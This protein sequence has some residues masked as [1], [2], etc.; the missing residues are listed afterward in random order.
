MKWLSRPME[1]ADWLAQLALLLA[2]PDEPALR[3]RGSRLTQPGKS[4]AEQR[5]H[6]LGLAYLAY[7]RQ[8]W[9]GGDI[10]AVVRRAEPIAWAQIR[11][12]A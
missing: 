8:D 9:Y 5:K 4:G 7:R 11:R 10:S 3:G 2:S 6:A 12:R 1:R